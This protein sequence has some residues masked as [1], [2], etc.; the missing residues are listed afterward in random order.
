MVHFSTSVASLRSSEIRDLMSLAN[1]PNMI[2]FSGGMPDNDLFPLQE[3]DAIYRRLT[4]REKQIALQYGPT[5]GLPQLLDSLSGFLRDKGLPVDTNKLLI[6]TGSL[7][8]IN[9]LGHAFIDPGDTILVEN[10][11]FIGAISAFR[12]YQANIVSIPLTPAGIDTEALGRTLDTLEAAP[13]FL[14][15]T[16]NFHNPA[17]TLYHRDT[18]LRLI[19]LLRDRNIPL[20]EDDA[21]SELYFHDEDREHLQTLKSMNPEGL[22]ICYTGSFSKILG[23]GLRLGWMLVPDEIYR[24]CELIKQSI[25]ACSPSFTQMIAHKFLESG[26]YLPYLNRIRAEYKRRAEA[27]TQLLNAQLPEGCT[28]TAPRGGFY[29]WIQLPGGADSTNI[30]KRAIDKGVVFVSGKTFDPHGMRNDRIRLSFCNSSVEKINEGI[31]LVVES[32]REELML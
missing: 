15:L 31:P 32:I 26:A 8:A 25:D 12:S 27:M 4:A 30:L 9:I 22:D 24:K 19:E 1:K 11:C 16:P 10:P 2:L 13:K 23:P 5:P 14:Y 6:T 20:I 18:K 7:Q 17:G 3:V 28:F 29:I 21:Y